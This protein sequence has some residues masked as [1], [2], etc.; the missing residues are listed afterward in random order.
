ML[1]SLLGRVNVIKINILPQLNY[2][3]QN[4]PCYLA[5]SF[6]KTLNSC[7]SRYIWNNK[8]QRVCLSKPLLIDFESLC[9]HPRRLD[10]LWFINNI[11]HVNSLTDNVIV[12][13]TLLVWN[14]VKKHSNIP[15]IMS[16]HSP[17]ALNPDFPT[18]IRSIRLRAWS[19]KGLSDFSG[20]FTSE[21]VKSFEQIR[22]EF[23]IPSEDFFYNVFK[24]YIL[25]SPY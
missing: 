6:F 7:I 3:F 11:N 14:D 23:N 22:T 4:L 2:L 15:Q 18:Q 9:C 13:T 8:Q 21:I 16:I 25:Y 1:I 24:F 17:L 12:Y 19:S 20:M 10:S 5:S